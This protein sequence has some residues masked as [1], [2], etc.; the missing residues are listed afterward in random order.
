MLQEME[1]HRIAEELGLSL[2]EDER[3]GKLSAEAIEQSKQEFRKEHP[4]GQLNPSR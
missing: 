2:A 4:Y 1:L 3:A